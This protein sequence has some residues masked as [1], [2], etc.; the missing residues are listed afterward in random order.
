MPWFWVIH[1]LVDDQDGQGMQLLP[2]NK[3]NSRQARSAHTNPNYTTG[4]ILQV[5]TVERLPTSLIRPN[6][7][8]PQAGP[9]SQVQ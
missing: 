4:V 7:P 9:K 5:T 8:R 3:G 2:A 6:A 1:V